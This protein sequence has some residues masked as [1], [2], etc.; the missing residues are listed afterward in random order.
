MQ[1]WMVLA[2][3]ACGGDETPGDGDATHWV[4]DTGSTVWPDSADTGPAD[5]GSADPGPKE[6]P[7][8]D[9]RRT[10]PHGVHAGSASLIGATGCALE[11]GTW[12]PTDA[13]E[14]PVVVLAHGFSR[15]PAQVAGWAEHLAGW[16]LRVLTPALCHASL[17]DTDHVGNGADLAA[18]AAWAGGGVVYAGHSAGGLAGLLAA[19]GDPSARGVIGLDLTDAEGLGEA[20]AGELAATFY[21]LAGE[22]SDCNSQGNGAAAYRAAALARGLRVSEADH[23]DFE[24]ATDWLCT[25]FCSGTNRRFDDAAVQ[26]TIRGLL[27]SAAVEAAGLAP[28]ADAWWQSG[29]AFHDALVAEGAVRPLAP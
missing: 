3:A 21:A 1:A 29:G 2:L 7:P 27:T 8:V 16:G 14:A 17:F 13:P 18:V 20:A 15:T 6:T 19:A 25:T 5:T 26:D 24:D 10:G 4:Q 23:C 22:P 12:G 28:A 11:V 9:Y